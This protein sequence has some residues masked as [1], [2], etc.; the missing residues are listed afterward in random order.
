MNSII[1]IIYLLM[2]TVT[3]SNG[4]PNEKQVREEILEL[5]RKEYG[6]SAKRMF[7]AFD[8]NNDGK[9]EDSEIRTLL[10]KSGGYKWTLKIV[11]DRLIHSLDK[12]GDHAVSYDEIPSE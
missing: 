6:S 8:R 7:A 1:L 4:L 10:Q 11:T 2:L 5:G 3:Y 12:N 9:L